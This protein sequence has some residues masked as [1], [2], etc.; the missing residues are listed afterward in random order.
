M[1]KARAQRHAPNGDVFERP[2]ACGEGLDRCE[3]DPVSG[4]FLEER[5]GEG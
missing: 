4:E 5:F 3:E 2:K 1:E